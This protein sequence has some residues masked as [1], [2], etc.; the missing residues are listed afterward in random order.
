M[1]QKKRYVLLKEFPSDLQEN[2]KFLFQNSSGYIIKT[3]L[4]GAEYFRTRALL[5]SGSIRK[6][7][8]QPKVLYP[9][10]TKKKIGMK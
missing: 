8:A 4:V 6:L 1:R 7:K 2:S 10:K 3:D 5:I 9:R